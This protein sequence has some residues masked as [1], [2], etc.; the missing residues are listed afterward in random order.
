[1]LMN[2][3]PFVLSVGLKCY[4]AL[5]HSR[6]REMDQ[7]RQLVVL[8]RSLLTRLAISVLLRDAPDVLRDAPDVPGDH[9]G[10]TV[11]MPVTGSMEYSMRSIVPYLRLRVITQL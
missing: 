10:A 6:S 8:E 11:R 7:V 5:K 9:L 4:E 1:M 3:V 2:R